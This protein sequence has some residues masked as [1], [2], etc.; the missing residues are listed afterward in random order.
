[1]N[2]VQEPYHQDHHFQSSRPPMRDH[3]HHHQQVTYA[4]HFESFEPNIKVEKEDGQKPSSSLACKRVFTSSSDQVGAELGSAG[5][6]STGG[7]TS[8]HSL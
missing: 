6:S 5:P 8:N 3:H 2:C 7:Y 4:D 1:M